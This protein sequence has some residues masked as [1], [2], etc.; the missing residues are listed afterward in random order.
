MVH[1]LSGDVAFVMNMKI[2]YFDA[3][4]DLST[5]K[6]RKRRRIRKYSQ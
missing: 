5:L 6:S 4:F 3:S 1:A 2:V